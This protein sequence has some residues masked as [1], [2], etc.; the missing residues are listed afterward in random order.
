VNY[1]Y[2]E[3]QW[4][5]D[6][7]NNERHHRPGGSRLMTTQNPHGSSDNET[8]D[9]VRSVAISSARLWEEVL[10]RLVRVERTQAE[11]TQTLARLQ[12]ALP[13]G[14]VAPELAGTATPALGSASPLPPPPIGAAPAI[15][16][17]GLE[18]PSVSTYTDVSSATFETTGYSVDTG[19]EHVAA[20]S[21]PPAPFATVDDYPGY[22]AGVAAPD[23]AFADAA[24]APV[25]A[26]HAP[27]PADPAAP[28]LG[29]VQTPSVPV[30]IT[31]GEVLPPPPPPPGFAG[32]SDLPPPPA[33]F[34]G[35]PYDTPSDFLA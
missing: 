29:D 10:E 14:S 34:S 8:A 30:P 22:G 25:D 18:I 9:L 28:H 7:Q 24:F 21:V 4:S 32:T 16:V 20:G 15:D 26:A 5:D 13:A 1:A 33:G 3:R 27:F 2:Y 31:T 35:Q 11:L 23:P 17:D 12:A 19:S 6:E